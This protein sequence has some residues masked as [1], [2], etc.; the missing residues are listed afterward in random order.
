M[1]EDSAS[2]ASATDGPPSD[3]SANDGPSTPTVEDASGYGLSITL[4]GGILLALGYYGYLAITGPRALGQALPEPFYLLAFAFL[5]V[6][7]LVTG[8][9]SGIVGVGRA[10]AFSVVY[11]SL[12]VLA[13]E[14]AVYI[15]EDPAVALEGFV[16]VTV[17]AVA[18]VVAALLYVAYLTAIERSRRSSESE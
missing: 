17:L 14:G 13:S 18:L 1:A 10:I 8:P 9:R 7:E 5:F 3:A 4:T 16:G 12:F 11:G 6:L 2:D 15:W